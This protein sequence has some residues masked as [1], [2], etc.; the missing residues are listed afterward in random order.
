MKLPLTSQD[1]IGERIQ[2]LRELFPEV[3]SEGK[4]NFHRF[5][6]LFGDYVS[7]DRE[8]YGLMWNGRSEAIKAIRT[9][10][11]GTL[12]PAPAESVKFESTRNLII[13]GDNLEV[14][15]LLQKGYQGKVKVIYI[16]P[17]YNTGKDFIYPD[18]YRE[19]LQTYLRFTGQVDEDGFKLTTNAETDGRFHSKWLTMMYPRLA[20]AKQLL[21]RDGVIFVSI[22]H[23]EVK[24]LRAIM[25]EIYGEENFV[26]DVAVVNNLKGRNDRKHI[27]TCH[28]H[29]LIYAMPEFESNGLPLS[30]K[31]RAE[32]KYV[33]VRGE[34]YALRD[35][36]RRGGND[37]REDRPDMYFP[38][39]YDPVSNT[40]S[41]ERRSDSDIEITPKRGDGTDGRWVWGRKKVSENLAILH[42]KYSE[43]TGRW[44]IDRRVYLNVNAQPQ[45]EDVAEDN[46]DQEDYDEEE[47]MER[48]AK[49]KSVWIGG[50]LSS[51]VG[52]RA[53][54]QLVPG[55]DLDYPKSVEFIK[56]CLHIGTNKKDN[57]IVLDFFAGSGTTAQAVLELNQQDSG[58]RQFILVQLPEPLKKP[59]Q[60]SNLAEIT[61]QRVR[62]VIEKLSAQITGEDGA[63]SPM[64]LGF[65]V[66]KLAS[67]NFKVWDGEAVAQKP[68]ELAQQLTWFADN[69]KPDRTAEDILYELLLKTGKAL[70][71]KIE[72]LT[73]A[74]Q[75]VFAVNGTEL[76]VCLAEEMSLDLIRALVELNPKAVVCLD[77]SFHGNDQLKTNTV[78]EMKSHD[79]MF[80]TV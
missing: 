22:D 6:E 67:S 31:Q 32:Y 59:H 72:T 48:T 1:V 66:F 2:K 55:V 64:D 69:L 3:F 56:W 70:T 49:P 36:R 41:L 17:P 25:D 16:D 63:A 14:L 42:P 37:R 62:K 65:K 15:K 61:K 79:I 26:M 46:N 40:C 78:L 74:G 4:I 29:L 35:L 12:C 23:R 77:S 7:E 38:I 43:R 51:D 21:R 28:E 39:Y 54:K 73:V 24:N 80:Q 47:L 18:N 34:L 76:F 75:E 58:N 33:D 52:K 57:D 53:F 71:S 13:E 8:L 9:V 5:K 20:L 45:P 11:V 60:D 10:S 19:G 27:A 44:D 68:D 50:E 30:E